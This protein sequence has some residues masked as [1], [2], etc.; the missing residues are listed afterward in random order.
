MNEEVENN[1][2]KIAVVP[3]AAPNDNVQKC[4]MT[5]GFNGVSIAKWMRHPMQ[6]I[7]IGGQGRVG[8]VSDTLFRIPK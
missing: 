2:I 8:K 7:I 4:L 1:G 3:N 5:L 6:T